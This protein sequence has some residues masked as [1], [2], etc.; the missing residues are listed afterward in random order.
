[1]SAAVSS[2]TITFG[3]KGGLK[4]KKMLKGE[5]KHGKEE[6]KGILKSWKK[7]KEEERKKKEEREKEERKTRKKNKKE[8][9][10]EQQQQ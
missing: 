10:K 1:M 6:G 8:K 5:K 3:G 7:K 2:I 4:S 9:T